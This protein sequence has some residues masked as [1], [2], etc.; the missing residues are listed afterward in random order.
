MGLIEGDAD[1]RRPGGGEV[2][3]LRKGDGEVW[4]LLFGERRKGGGWILMLVGC[5]IAMRDY[6]DASFPA[7]HTRADIE[8]QSSGI[9]FV[10]LHRWLFHKELAK[11]F[12][13]FAKTTI[14][15]S[16]ARENRSDLPNNKNL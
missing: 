6:A 11:T 14:A 10:N 8:E 5:R 13:W 7:R 12:L 3:A 15:D 4:M 9:G 2:W 1:A 16:W